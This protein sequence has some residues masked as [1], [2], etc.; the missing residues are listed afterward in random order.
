MTNPIRFFPLFLILTLFAPLATMGQ[1][2][3][4]QPNVILIMADDLGYEGLSCYGSASYQTPNLD[5]LAETGMRFTHCYSQ[6]ICTPSRVQLMTGRYNQ[7]NY[8]G[9]GYLDPQEKTFGNLL[10]EAGY[11]TCIAGKW[12][13]NGRDNRSPDSRKPGWEDTSRPHAFGFDEYLLWQLNRGRDEGERYANPLLVKNGVELER[14]KEAYGPDL[15]CDFIVDF[16][17]RS[18]DRPFFVYFP[19]ALVH[20]PFVPTPADPEW[21]ENSRRYE[22]S[23]DKFAP[24]IAY[25]DG[26]VARLVDALEKEGL[27]EKTLIMF[28]G[29]N[30]NHATITTTM[31]D[32]RRL[33]GGKGLMTDGGTHVPLIANWPG[34]IAPGVVTDALVDFTDFLPTLLDVSGACP[35]GVTLDGKSFLNLLVGSPY[36]P[37]S[38]IFSHYWGSRGRTRDGAR[39][40]VRNQR[41]KLYD[42]GS[43][44]NIPADPLEESP[45]KDAEGDAAQARALLE[46]AFVMVRSR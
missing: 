5:R 19:M 31:Q 35:P 42:D 40:W 4:N 23:T 18:K 3:T 14:D 41:W 34:R 38:W 20:E 24:M 16:I 12:Q 17:R 39:E 43:L 29:D 28:T 13:L 2:A 36:Q 6:P 37:R 7:R 15:F 32:G 33:Q 10:K 21:S 26:I 1:E 30:G 11:A 22:E 45:V 44:Y 27:R 25:M 8:H 9:F 46:E